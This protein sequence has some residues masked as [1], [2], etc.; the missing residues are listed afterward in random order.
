MIRPDL[1]TCWPEG[2]DYPLW[3]EQLRR[4][5]GHLAKVI[6]VFTSDSITPDLRDFVRAAIP[7]AT[8]VQAPPSD[9]WYDAAFRAA[10]A[11]STAEWVWFT[12]Q[13]FFY[14]PEF[15][16]TLLT[17]VGTDMV[18]IDTPRTDPGCCLVRRETLDRCDVGFQSVPGTLLDNFDAFSARVRETSPWVSLY[19]LD[20]WRHMNGLSHNHSLA[21]RGEP[22]TYKPFEF[23]E[24][25]RA[26]LDGPMTLAPSWEREAR[27]YLAR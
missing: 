15:L 2:H 13:D 25:L 9:A 17:P 18:S 6:I 21:H 12:E 7:Y 3:R 27:A 16:V 26:C 24:Y 1:I 22:V 23:E 19:G 14:T 20:G 5:A 8:F 10:L 4:D 11:E